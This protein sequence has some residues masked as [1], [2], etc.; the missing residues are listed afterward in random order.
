MTQP[1]VEEIRAA[2]NVDFVG[3]GYGEDARLGALITVVWAWLG[4]VTGQTLASLPEDWTLEPLADLV[5][6]RKVE[7]LAYALQ[8]DQIETI[9]DFKLISSFSAGSYSETRRSLDE[10]RKNVML[11]ADPLVNELLWPLLTDE[12]KDEMLGLLDDKNAPAFAITEVDWGWV[13]SATTAEDLLTAAGLDTGPL[14]SETEPWQ[15]YF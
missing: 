6:Q 7:M 4:N 9:A 12:K 15:R 8:A 14:I 13:G 10:L 1:T 2:S 3:Q 11:D 5:V